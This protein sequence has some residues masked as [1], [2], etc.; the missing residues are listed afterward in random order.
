MTLR[1][2]AVIAYLR[3]KSVLT[4]FFSLLNH[5]IQ[6]NSQILIYFQRH[7]TLCVTNEKK[8]TKYVTPAYRIN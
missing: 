8:L 3:V 7:I 6:R 2:Y 1:T 4:E 5:H